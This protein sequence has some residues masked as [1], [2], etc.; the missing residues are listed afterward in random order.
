MM[1]SLGDPQ[2]QGV[3]ADLHGDPA[4]KLETVVED[5]H[6]AMRRAC[7]LILDRVSQSS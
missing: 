7:A 3:L 4:D 6:R 1:R 2:G 5:L